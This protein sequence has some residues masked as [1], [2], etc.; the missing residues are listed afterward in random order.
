MS[1]QG[2][3]SPYVS[4]DAGRPLRAASPTLKDVARL[5]GVHPGT[6]SRALDPRRT[7]LVRPE[8]RAKVQTAARKLGYRA[9][10]VARS[11]RRGET[12]TIGVAAADL[13][14]PFIGPLLRGLANALDRHG[15]M[16]FVSETQDERE[17]LLASLDNFLSRRVDA[18]VVTAA[19]VGDGAILRRVVAGGLPV[20]LA[21]RAVPGSGV[22]AVTSDDLA[23]GRLAARHL[24]EL[25]HVVAAQLPGPSDVQPFVD[26]SVGF[27]EEAARAGIEAVEIPDEA[28]YPT[29]SEGRRLMELLLARDGARPT[30]VFA[31]NDSMAIGAI[32]VLRQAGLHCPDDISVLG[33]NDAPF[34]DH[35]SPPLSTIRFPGNEIGRFT[36]EIAV[37]LIKEPHSMVTSTTFPPE[38]VPRAS[39][40]PPIRRRRGS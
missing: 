12:T 16:A 23:G 18:I 22:P 11:L 9:D 29:V 39:T 3:Q 38:L 5:A 30:A 17:R 19:H 26:R 20:V 33:Y 35:L 32:A 31:H 37:A 15:F 24:A 28:R 25:G 2:A 40:R 1:G 6:V 36:A 10:A 21:V 34:V 13:G 4:R 7:S 8:T 27:A 14:N